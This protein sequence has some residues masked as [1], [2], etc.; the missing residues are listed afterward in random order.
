MGLF[1]GTAIRDRIQEQLRVQQLRGLIYDEE[2]DDEFYDD[3]EEEEEEYYDNEEE[4]WACSCPYGVKR[5]KL[6][7]PLVVR[8]CTGQIQDRLKL[9]NQLK[10]SPDF[11]YSII[12]KCISAF[13]KDP[14]PSVQRWM[15]NA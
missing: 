14:L 7:K 15:E 11:S 12:S 9:G 8:G 13:S 1:Q 4:K 6:C 5:S 2:V 10:V 3:S